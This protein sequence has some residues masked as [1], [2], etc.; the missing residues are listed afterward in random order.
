MNARPLLAAAVVVLC[1]AF[2][3]ADEPSVVRP[4]VLLIVSDDQGVNDV[5]CYGSEIPTPALDALA[6]EGLKFEQFYAASSICTPSRFGLLTGRFA[7][8]SAD[9]LTGA[10]MFL[11]PADAQRGLRADETTFVSLLKKNGYRTHL[12][13]KWHLG[14]GTIG[15][16]GGKFW[17]TE[18]GFD[19][20]FGHTGGCVDFFTCRYGNVPDWYRGE[21]LVPTDAYA[22]DVITD[23]AVALI[24]GGKRD[25]SEPWFLEVAYNA[26]HYGKGWDE[27]ANRTRNVMQPKPADLEKVTRLGSRIENPLRRAFAA[28]VVG[29]DAG[30]ARLLDALEES[31]QAED[32]LVIFMSDHGGDPDYGGSNAPLRGEKATLYEGGVRVPCLVRWPGV[33]QPGATTDAVA[34]ALDWFPTFADLGLLEDAPTNLDGQSIAPLLRGEPLPKHVPIVW[35]TGSH[36]ELDRAAWVAVRDGDW[37]WVRHKGDEALFDLAADPRETTNRLADRPEIAARLRALAD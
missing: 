13:G 9:A 19:T 16:G 36:A 24:R 20:F 4:N 33:V 25:E 14:H 35:A 8:R 7:H 32:T 5:G 31:G 37:K 1:P 23:E 15:E 34:T 11:D 6:A 26:P 28:K 22:T 21:E 27:P 18:H 30:I 12:V 2:A 3:G 29:M 17:P 10:L